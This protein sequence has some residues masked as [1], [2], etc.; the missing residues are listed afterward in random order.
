VKLSDLKPSSGL[1][2]LWI[3][4]VLLVFVLAY[5]VEDGDIFLIGFLKPIYSFFYLAVWDFVDFFYTENG[6]LT[7]E[8]NKHFYAWEDLV[9][10]VA[11][12][13]TYILISF[14]GYLITLW[15]KIGFAKNADSKNK[16]LP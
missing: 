3:G 12:T 14:C 4:S 1:T 6:K 11:I 16:P 9:I 13:L 15:I 5:G 8:F 10:G 7:L 2:R